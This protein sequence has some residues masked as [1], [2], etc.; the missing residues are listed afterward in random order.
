MIQILWSHLPAFIQTI[1]HTYC[2][3]EYT[4]FSNI[5]SLIEMKGL[6]NFHYSVEVGMLDQTFIL[7]FHFIHS[8]NCFHIRILFYIMMKSECY[9]A[10]NMIGDVVLYKS[11]TWAL[12]DFNRHTLSL[13]S[14]L[15]FIPFLDQLSHS[16]SNYSKIHYA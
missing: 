14:T 16:Q 3:C 7:W 4:I 9:A 8:C 11:T 12:T 10:H 2:K 6:H 1:R 5:F 15:E 13:R